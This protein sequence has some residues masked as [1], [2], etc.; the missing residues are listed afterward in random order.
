M[1]GGLGDIP[2]VCLAYSMASEN[3][4]GSGILVMEYVVYASRGG[5]S[6]SGR[7]LLA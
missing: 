7:V 4:H 5:G 3:L 1:I 6:A 2:T